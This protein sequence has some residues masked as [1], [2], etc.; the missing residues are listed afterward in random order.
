MSSAFEPKAYN[1]MQYAHRTKPKRTCPPRTPHATPGTPP[2]RHHY[3]FTRCQDQ[4]NQEAPLAQ[5]KAS[6]DECAKQCATHSQ[7]HSFTHDDDQCRLYGPG[8][9]ANATGKT[10]YRR[11]KHSCTSSKA[12]TYVHYSGEALGETVGE[13]AGLTPPECA[14]ICDVDPR[15]G[16][17][18]LDNAQLCTLVQ[19][20]SEYMVAVPADKVSYINSHSQATQ[21]SVPIRAGRNAGTNRSTA[22]RSASPL[23]A[24]SPTHHNRASTTTS[25]IHTWPSTRA[26]RLASWTRWTPTRAAKRAHS[27]PTAAPSSSNGAGRHSVRAH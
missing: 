9:V 22:S 21:L 20:R 27:I 16:A 10:V 18:V 11:G 2:D 4:A 6:F 25:S 15:C 26:P 14:A 13:L 8:A 3:D 17:F 24:P 5:H 23:P 7:C 19:H 12:P 1:Y